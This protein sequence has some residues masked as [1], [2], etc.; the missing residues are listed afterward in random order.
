MNKKEKR[1]AL[2]AEMEA[3]SKKV[4]DEKRAFTD[5]E[6]KAFDEKEAEV[7]KLTAEI[8]DETRN[9]TLEEFA[10]LERP[11][12]E[13]EARSKD[14]SFFKVEKRAGGVELR[15]AMTQADGGAA[16]APEQFVHDIIKAVEK[17]ALVYPRVKKIAV[18]GAGS[19]G[20]P[21]EAADASSA[22]WTA[23]VPAN[24]IGADSTWAFGKRS[25]S[26]TDLTK[27]IKVSKKLLATSAFPIDTLAKEKIAE[28]LTAAFENAIIN[29]TGVAAAN[30]GNVNQ[31]LGLFVASNDGV[32]TARD[33][34]TKESLA[35]S[36]DD[37]INMYMSL[38]PGYR[39]K[40]VWIMNTAILKDVMLLKDKNDQYLWHE[41][42]R[43]GEPSTLMGLPVLESEYAPV[44]SGSNGALAGGDY[45]MVLG[46]LSHY[47]F[48]YWK[49]M[50]I[51]VANEVF[52]G[53]NQ[54][55]FYGHTLA[56][57]MPT[58]AEAFSRLKIKAA[59]QNGGN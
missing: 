17:E 7:R 10:G 45:V 30:S 34:E 16:I 55:G 33:V 23:E 26:P 4:A 20:L 47:Q 57:G 29:G 22:A 54:I 50:D 38:R 49:G 15:T 46:D 8:E 37:I 19:L 52:A 35:I 41:S 58:L 18:N 9:K 40:A 6:R 56:D 25:L 44:G 24:A 31:P 1:S 36:A 53:T 51:T 42:L 59:A 3:I 12:S 32:S 27:L 39:R 28:K 11:E 43:V 13:P 5:E 2:I 48:A 14:E 21:Y